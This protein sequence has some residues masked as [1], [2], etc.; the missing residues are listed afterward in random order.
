MN[1]AEF[2]SQ[3]QQVSTELGSNDIVELFSVSL[4]GDMALGP[5]QMEVVSSLARDLSRD[6][7]HLGRLVVLPKR[8]LTLHRVAQSYC[9]TDVKTALEEFIGYAVP[10][11]RRISERFDRTVIGLRFFAYVGSRSWKTD[12]EVHVRSFVETSLLPNRVVRTLPRFPRLGPGAPQDVTRNLL[13][14]LGPDFCYHFPQPPW[15][16]PATGGAD[17]LQ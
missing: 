6:L 9:L 3:A 2:R 4:M 8:S 1:L 11:F 7:A 14:T 5:S 12:A 16:L 17:M 10:F 15:D 13:L